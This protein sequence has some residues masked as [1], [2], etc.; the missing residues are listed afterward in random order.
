MKKATTSLSLRMLFCLYWS[1]IFRKTVQQ[2]IVH[3][4]EIKMQQRFAAD[5]KREER[6]SKEIKEI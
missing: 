6:D 3:S 2:I 4:A 1:W 5:R